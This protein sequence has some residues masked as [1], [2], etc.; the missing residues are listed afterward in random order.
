MSKG[1]ISITGRLVFHDLFEPGGA[2]GFPPKYSATLQVGKGTEDE[3]LIFKTIDQV[4]QSTWPN[5]WQQKLVDIHSCI[6]SGAKPQNSLIS[7]Q[8]GDLFQPDYNAG[9]WVLKASR[10]TNQGPPRVFTKEGAQCFSESD[11]GCPGQGWGVNA[12]INVWAQAKQD[13]VNFTV[14]AIRGALR[15]VSAGGPPPEV[16]DREVAGFIEAA[17]ATPVVAIPGV[18]T[19]QETLPAAAGAP[20]Q[21]PGGVPTAQGAIVPPG[22]SQDALFREEAPK[23]GKLLKL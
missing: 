17:Q 10:R 21:A 14:I 9:F 12:L 20:Q 5:E 11:A 15:G 8:D 7:L 13:R 3:A 16:V 4:A 1:N 19:E 23:T 22:P 18:V 2:P 6:T